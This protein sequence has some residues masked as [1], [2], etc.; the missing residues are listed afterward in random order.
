LLSSQC[1]GDVQA[2]YM[3]QLVSARR[4]PSASVA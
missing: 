2:S 4:R 3:L 1:W